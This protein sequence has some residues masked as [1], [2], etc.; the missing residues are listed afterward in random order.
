VQLVTDELQHPA[1]RDGGVP[2]VALRPARVAESERCQ[3]IAVAAWAPIYAHRRHVLGDSL[4]DR[5]HRKWAERKAAE[6]AAAFRRHPA[7]I[8]VAVAAS[9]P[10]A[11]PAADEAGIASLV[12]FV[13]YRLDPDRRIG[14]IGN[15]A[16]DPAWQGRGIASALYRR[17][18]DDFRA[19]GMEVAAVTTGLDDAHAP[20]R[21]AY[22]G[23][24]FAAGVPSVTLYRE[25]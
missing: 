5:L 14:T 24:G 19:A 10:P 23:A 17:A 1:G 21:A 22:R 2:G 4:F 12:G 15:N 13:T 20:A 16:V 8:V 25:L 3:A 7:W 6:I 11:P 9:E 18:L